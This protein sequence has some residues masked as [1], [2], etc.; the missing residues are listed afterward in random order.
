MQ[1]TENLEDS[2]LLVSCSPHGNLEAAVIQ[3]KRVAYLYLA[4]PEESPFGTKACWIRNLQEAPATIDFDGMD[5]GIAPM[6]PKEYCKY[7]EGQAPLEEKELE[8]VWFPEGDGAALLQ[9]DEFVAIIPPWG[10]YEGFTGYSRDCIGESPLCWALQD[11]AV[12]DT[13]IRDAK[14]Y[15]ASWQSEDNPWSIYQPKIFEAY[16]KVLGEHSKYYAID[17]GY[18]PPKAIVRFDH[19]NCVYLLSVGVSLRPQPVIEMV[20]EDSSPHRRIE[21]AACLAKDVGEETIDSF[22]KYLSGQTN[23]PWDYFTFFGFNH[24]VPCD[25][26]ASQFALDHLKFLLFAKEPEGAPQFNLPTLDGDALNLLWCIPITIKEQQFAEEEN[27]EALVAKFP[28]GK[29]PY[30]IQGR[31]PLL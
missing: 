19:E 11:T 12:M 14:S 13:R 6:L 15:W 29:A 31:K 30:L 23:L 22:A 9:G 26:F 17:G 1:D 21:F 8:V 2:P 28:S 10:G 7:P 27:S 4:G 25:A 3:D 20:F 24:T 16:E 5:E 18:W